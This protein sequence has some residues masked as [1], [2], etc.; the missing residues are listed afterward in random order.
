MINS[1]GDKRYLKTKNGVVRI[2]IPDTASNRKFV[3]LN[4]VE[5][6]TLTMAWPIVELLDEKDNWTGGVAFNVEDSE[7]F[8]TSEHVAI[9]A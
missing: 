2:R 8:N 3:R 5:Q 4:Y 7:L 6:N 1:I 9:A